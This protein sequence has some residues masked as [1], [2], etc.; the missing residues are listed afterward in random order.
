MR[1]RCLGILAGLAGL[2]LSLIG[3]EAPTNFVPVTP[4]GAPLPPKTT[5]DDPPVAQ[6][7]MAAPPLESTA[8]AAVKAI[9]YVPAPPTAKGQTK[10]TAHGVTYETLTEGTGRELKPGQDAEFFYVGK[11]EDGTVFDDDTRKTNKPVRTNLG[12]M[13]EGWKD[14]LPGMKVGEL[15]KLM[16]PPEMA[17]GAK[18][19]QPVIPP[20]ATLIF[21]VELVRILSN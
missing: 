12:T 20:N 6:G 16:I 4:P 1:L 9:E 5:D 8:K 3:C 15:R 17:Y 7:E 18:G 11:L 10:K 2:V 13:I 19:R 21:E 14:A